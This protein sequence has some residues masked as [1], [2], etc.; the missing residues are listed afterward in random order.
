MP[1]RKLIAANWKMYKTPDD[2]RAFLHSFLPLVVGH[3]RD[4]I[5]ICPPFVDIFAALE[6]ARGSNVGVGAQDVYW[7]NEGAFTGEV[8]APMLVA[9]G[10][11]HVIIGH[12]ER[13]QFFGE[14]DDT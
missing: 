14:T 3:M 6:S 11:T 1:R 2:A 9:A 4:E 7:K 10:C 8:S 13:R 5:V 12:S